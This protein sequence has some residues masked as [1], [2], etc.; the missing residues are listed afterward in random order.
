VKAPKL[1]VWD[2]TVTV[3][4]RGGGSWAFTGTEKVII[5]TTAAFA[6]S[7]QTL[8]RILMVLDLIDC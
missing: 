3:I 7:K 5:N 8:R 1:R 6:R 4:G 2:V